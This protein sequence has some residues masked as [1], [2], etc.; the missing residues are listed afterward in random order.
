MGI[1]LIKHQPADQRPR[2]VIRV[3]FYMRVST[4]EQELE[5][6]SPEF[7]KGQL[8]EHVQRK[9]YRGWITKPE[10][11]FFDVGSGSELEARD[12][13][14][15]LMALV[16]AGELDIVLVWKIDRLSRNLSD[17]LRLFDEFNRH[18]V[19]FASMKEDLDFTGPIGRLIYQVFGALA[20]FERETI[21]MRTEEG[22][23][24]SAL[25]GNYTG[26]V[27]PYGFKGVPNAGGKGRKLEVVP[28][29]AAIVRRVFDW[30]VYD[31]W[32]AGQIAAELNRL[33]VPKGRAN[34]MVRGTNWREYTVRSMLGSEEYRGVFITNRY[35]LVQKK[36]RRHEERP[37]E[38]WI[39]VQMPAIIDDV[40]FYMSQE[41]LRHTSRHPQGGGGR[42]QYML[43]GKLVEAGTGRGFVGYVSTKKTKNYRRKQYTADGVWHSSMSVAARPLE[44]F[45][46]E[47]IEKAISRPDEFL[48]MHREKVADGEAKRK[49]ADEL[50]VYEEQLSDLNR[51]IEK[52]SE[53]YYAER[54]ADGE[55]Q[56]W[57]VKYKDKRD[58]AF[59]GKQRIEGELARLG[60]YGAACDYLREFSGKMKGAA[61]DFGEAE[62]Q[63]LVDLLVDRIEV[64]DSPDDRWATVYFRFDPKEIAM[65]MPEVEPAL[66][67][68]KPKGSTSV[69]SNDGNGGSEGSGCYLFAFTTRISYLGNNQYEARR[70]GR[71]TGPLP[72]PKILRKSG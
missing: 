25:A 7:Q 24:A 69:A 19:G 66:A 44:T 13:L 53:D 59:Q 33:G 41:R 35:R 72:A 29:E 39:V 20:E 31:R 9:A 32:N 28:D 54:I 65:H 11:H 62:K 61:T 15:R 21:K 26:T 14:Q 27:A 40:L 23:K 63:A 16:R 42:E 43:R 55:R 4:A 56:E 6:Y 52:V 3:A 64:A 8:L 49:L 2:D 71:T 60:E 38:E 68:R 48:R 45:V 37:K 30:F 17:L 36:P 58:A 57:T 50:R 5:G 10:W 47:R 12:K 1:S 46:W 70:D 51:K 22:R 18:R 34:T 67:L